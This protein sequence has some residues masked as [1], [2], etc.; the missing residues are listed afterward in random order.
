[1]DLKVSGKGPYTPQRAVGGPEQESGP[2]PAC[3][4]QSE[5]LPGGMLGLLF[6]PASLCVLSIQLCE[7]GS[8]TSIFQ[9]GVSA[10]QIA[11]QDASPSPP[12]FAS[13]EGHPGEWE[14]E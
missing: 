10:R 4:Q 12:L 6:F 14:T 1:M 13:E 7:A 8:N 3:S 5:L 2:D 11:A 9:V